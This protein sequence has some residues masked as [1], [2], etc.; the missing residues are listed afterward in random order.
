MKREILATDFGEPIVS[1]AVAYGVYSADVWWR[2]S[3]IGIGL[4]GAATP[5]GR[6]SQRPPLPGCGIIFGSRTFRLP[7]PFP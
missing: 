3:R 4:F 1:G 7:Y 2:R 5:R 6:H